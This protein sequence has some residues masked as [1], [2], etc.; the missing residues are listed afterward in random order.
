MIPLADGELRRDVTSAVFRL[1][2]QAQM[3]K[4]I[5]DEVDRT[6][7]N[8]AQIETFSPTSHDA[9]REQ[10]EKVA[11]NSAL[12]DQKFLEIIASIDRLLRSIGERIAE[13]VARRQIIERELGR[14][15]KA[16]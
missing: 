3:L 14:F 4:V 11:E 5:K 9:V 7:A 13:A 1:W 15:F 12:Q 10:A 2:T 6:Q 16:K 8:L